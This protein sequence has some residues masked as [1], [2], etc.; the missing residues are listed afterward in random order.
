MPGKREAAVQGKD[1]PRIAGQGLIGQA[2]EEVAVAD[3]QLAQAEAVQDSIDIP[4]EVLRSVRGKQEG[5]CVRM[6]PY[7][8][9]QYASQ[10]PAHRALRG[11]AGAEMGYSESRKTLSGQSKLGGGPGAVEPLQNHEV[12]Q[13]LL[14]RR[15]V[16]VPQWCP[17]NS[18][19]KNRT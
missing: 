9:F 10:K 6:G 3:H 12:V 14:M 13:D 16:N 19:R 15:R 18:G 2:G 17:P 1:E 7:P 8:C 11:L 4:M 5:H